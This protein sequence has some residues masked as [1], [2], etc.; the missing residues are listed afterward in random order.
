MW[1]R[2]HAKGNDISAGGMVELCG[3]QYRSSPHQVGGKITVRLNM[4]PSAKAVRI[5]KMT[6][7]RVGAGVCRR[8]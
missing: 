6:R 8:F 2:G 1:S 5:W 4:R 7:S 3:A